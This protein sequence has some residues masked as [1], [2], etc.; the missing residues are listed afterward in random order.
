VARLAPAGLDP[1]AVA[2][3]AASVETTALA[4]TDAAHLVDLG[5]TR[6]R[7]RRPISLRGE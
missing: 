5:T 6:D 7:G 2:E 4:R 3:A 1:D